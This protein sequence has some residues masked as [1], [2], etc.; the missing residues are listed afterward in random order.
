VSQITVS[1]FLGRDLILPQDRF[2]DAEQGLWAQPQE[3][4]RWALGLAEPA[5]LMAGGVRQVEPLVEEGEAVE[6]GQLVVLVLTGK[7]KYVQAPLAGVVSFPPELEALAPQ[8]AKDPYATTLFSITGPGGQP[9]GLA[10][11]AAFAKALSDS[12][13][14]RNPS[15]ATG[16]LSPTCKGVYQGIGGQRLAGGD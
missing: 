13:G 15:G 3:G 16:A 7:L 8:A 6:A 14:S 9:G 1:N 11:A 2:Y 12:D 10:D 5:V 4:G